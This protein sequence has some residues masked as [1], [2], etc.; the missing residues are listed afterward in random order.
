MRLKALSLLGTVFMLTAQVSAQEDKN[1]VI[2]K[3]YVKEAGTNE[4][5][6]G[7]SVAVVNIGKGTNADATGAFALN[8]EKGTQIITISFIGYRTITDTLNLQRNLTRTYYLQPDAILTETFTITDEVTK[9][10]VESTRMSTVELKME[11]VKKIP[12]IFGEVDILKTLQLLPG[13]QGAGEG[14]AGFYV[15]GGGPDQNLILLDGAVV[16]NAAH[17]FGFFSVFNSDAIRSVELIKG[18]MPAEYGGRL[19]SVLNISIKDGNMKEFHGEGGIGLIASRFTF[20]G[21]IVKDKLSFLVSARRTY[22]DL[23]LLPFSTPGSQLEGNSY[24]FYDL[25]AKLHWKVSE[26]DNIYLSGYFGQD[27]FNFKSPTSEFRID[28]PWGNAVSSLR[29]NRQISSK[30]FTNNTLAFTDYQFETNAEDE[31]FGFGLRS[32]IRDFTYKLDFDWKVHPRHYVKFGGEYTFHRFTPSTA[33]ARFED[34]I[35]VPETIQNLYSHDAAIYI[36]DEIDISTRIKINVGGRLTYYQ[37]TGPF[38]RY[39]KNESGIITDTISYKSFENIADYLR[40]E[41]RFSFRYRLNESSSIKGAFTMNYQNMHLANLSTVS[42]P[43]DVWLPSTSI[44]R[45]Q[46]A[47]QGNLGYFKNFLNDKIETSIEVYYKHMNNLVE[48]RDNTSFADLI[49]D[50]PDNLLTF[51][52]GRSYGAEFFVKKAVGKWTGWIGYTLSWTQRFNFDKNEIS[53]QGDFFYPRYDRRHDLSVTVSWDVSKKVNL[54]AVFVYATGNALAVPASYYFVGSS[55]VPHFEDRDNF[56]LAPYHRMDLSC[57]W[58]V[59]RNDKWNS[60]LN[61]SVY[62][63]YSRLNPFFVYFNIERNEDTG[64]IGFSGKQVSLFPIIPSVTWNFSF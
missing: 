36:Q 60:S 52:D 51:G 34:N 30:F 13:V 20:E 57:T 9:E 50:N 12:A 26:K 21:P 28:I 10:N 53:Y 2:L 33:R 40:F 19:S 37:H 4:P 5:L 3:G 43:T 17:L 64:A 1:R 25:N 41:P 7:A 38:D 16:Y 55:L 6:L 18:G 62:N 42:L 47:I 8:L 24:F 49:N 15:R 35:I 39:V 31:D 29:W 61:F 59:H 27:V 11:Q 14:N 45:P 58:E 54:A 46:Q 32:G 63:A 23:L 44:I 56:R 22:I 48:Y